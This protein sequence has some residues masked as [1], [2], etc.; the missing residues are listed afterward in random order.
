MMASRRDEI[1][2]WIE[3]VSRLAGSV[4]LNAVRVRWKLVAW[5]EKWHEAFERNRDKA[6]HV[7]YEHRVCG[8]CGALADRSVK[9]CPQCGDRLVPRWME[10]LNRVGLMTP[11]VASISTLL[12]LACLAAY[13]R[14]ALAGGSIF[15]FDGETLFTFGGS[16]PPAVWQGQWWRVATYIFLHGGALHIAFNLIALMQIGPPV[17]NLFGRGR[18][19]FV[20]MITGVVAGV[21]SALLRP[22]GVGIGASGS[23]MGIIGLAAGWGHREGTSHGIGIRNAMIKWGLYTLVFGIM[24]RA[25]NTAH[26]AGFL[27]GALLGLMY[28]PVYSQPAP[29]SIARTVEALIGFVLAAGAFYLVMIPPDASAFLR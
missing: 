20:F 1:P 27:S 2:D 16:F 29:Q 17:E 19:L 18:F 4:G 12:A 10:I 14:V 5:R 7:K 8:R 28:Q 24:I 11:E 3:K 15:A 23:L 21:A 13:A 6:R 26:T 25:D 22:G 9:V